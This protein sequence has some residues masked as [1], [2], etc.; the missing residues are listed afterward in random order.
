MTC[1]TMNILLVDDDEVDVMNVKRAF[2]KNNVSNPLHVAEN[3]IEA[4]EML[5]G[6]GDPEQRLRPKIILLDLNMPRMNGIDFLKELRADPDLKSISV[7]VLTTS[8]EERDIVAA[9]DFNVAGYIL[10]PV[11]FDK[12]V[13][14]IKTLKLYWKLNE[15]P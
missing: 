10:K 9:H 2:K 12:F 6:N 8:N 1:D 7:I 5:R 11:E 15:L 4:L 14:A 3:G 13:A